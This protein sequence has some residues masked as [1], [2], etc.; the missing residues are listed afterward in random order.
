MINKIEKPKNKQDL[1]RA[2]NAASFRMVDVYEGSDIKN[3][4]TKDIIE[5]K[6]LTVII[7]G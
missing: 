6:N 4:P 1:I 7:I 5:R 3:I 2:L